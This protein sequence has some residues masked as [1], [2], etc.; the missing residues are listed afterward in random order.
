MIH[1]VVKYWLTKCE[2]VSLAA[3][4]ADMKLIGAQY[5]SAASGLISEGGIFDE[6]KFAK[7]DHNSGPQFYDDGSPKLNTPDGSLKKKQTKPKMLRI[8]ECTLLLRQLENDLAIEEHRM[9][10]RLLM[11]IVSVIDNMHFGNLRDLYT[12]VQVTRYLTDCNQLGQPLQFEMCWLRQ[13]TEILK[14]GTD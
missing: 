7:S 3:G 13:E 2:M 11:G 1:G 8:S 14:S 4:S 12:E 5:M 6:N 10:T 9:N